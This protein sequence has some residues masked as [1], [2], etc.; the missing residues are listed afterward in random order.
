M[1]VLSSI[2]TVFLAI[3]DTANRF[4][5]LVMVLSEMRGEM[6]LSVKGD[7]QAKQRLEASKK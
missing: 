1:I 5:K 7:P 4:D 6:A 3:A 2:P